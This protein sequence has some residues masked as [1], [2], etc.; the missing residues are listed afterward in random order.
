M[1]NADVLYRLFTTILSRQGADPKT[2]WTAKLFA[3][4]RNKNRAK[5]WRGS[6]GNEHRGAD[7]RPR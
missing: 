4:G 6:D 1:S 5:G 3:Q 7:R 2:S